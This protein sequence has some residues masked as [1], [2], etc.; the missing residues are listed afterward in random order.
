[1]IAAECPSTERDAPHHRTRHPLGGPASAGR[2]HS[3]SVAARGGCSTSPTVAESVR[4]ETTNRRAA[5]DFL[6]GRLGHVV[7]GKLS[8][9]KSTSESRGD[10]PCSYD[11][12]GEWWAR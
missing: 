7:Q 2:A 11:R 6:N 5:Q 12:P 9:A 8:F 3:T 1:M 10:P 4:A